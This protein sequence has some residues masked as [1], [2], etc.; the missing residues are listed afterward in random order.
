VLESTDP[1]VIEWVD[2][3][4]ESFVADARRLSAVVENA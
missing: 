4:F 1:A 2:D 3:R